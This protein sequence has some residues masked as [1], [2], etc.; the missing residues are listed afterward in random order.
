MELAPNMK[1]FLNEAGDL[2]RF[3]GRFFTG[4]Q[5]TVRIQR[6]YQAMF[7][8]RLQVVATGWVNGIHHGPGTDHAVAAIDG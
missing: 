6:I 1:T 8:D 7:C 2:S 5:A 4:F 3:A